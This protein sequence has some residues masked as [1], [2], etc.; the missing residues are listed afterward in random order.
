MG[1]SATLA[2]AKRDDRNEEELKGER[3]DAEMD[4]WDGILIGD[5]VV[6]RLA[7]GHDDVCSQRLWCIALHTQ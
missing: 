3:R 1:L 2:R 5:D 7:R 6:V 4:V